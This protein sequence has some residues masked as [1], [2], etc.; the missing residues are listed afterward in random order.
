[1]KNKINLHSIVDVITNSSTEMFMTCH[2]NTINNVKNLINIILKNGGSDKTADDLYDIKLIKNT[3]DDNDEEIQ[4][5][6]VDYDEYE[7]S[8]PYEL[9]IKSK[10]GT[11]T[12]I[13][14]LINS[15][16]ENREFMC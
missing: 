7:E 9:S 14:E 15:I 4:E 8:Q 13:T 6:V 16:F 12:R 1:M 10:D 5:E 11:D 3:Y 2:S